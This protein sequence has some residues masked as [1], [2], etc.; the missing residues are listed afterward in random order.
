MNSLLGPSPHAGRMSFAIAIVRIIVGVA[1]IFHGM[2]KLPHP[3][4]WMGPMAFAPGWLQ[5]VVTY[6]EFL[7]GIALIA[8]LLTRVAALLIA[9]DMIVAIFKVHLPSGG[10]FVGGRGSFEVPLVY[11]VVMIGLIVAGPG[12][13]SLDALIS[14]R[15]R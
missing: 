1:F 14:R 12:Y 5:G 9:I 4:D 6:V 7:G 11:L 8:G 3:T 15:A 13:Y 2:T 10:H